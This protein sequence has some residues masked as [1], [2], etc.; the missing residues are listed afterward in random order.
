[1]I[2]TLDI[3]TVFAWVGTAVCL[4]VPIL[5]TLGLYANFGVYR[6]TGDGAGEGGGKWKP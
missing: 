1:M 2:V 5:I 3:E 6:K 4:L